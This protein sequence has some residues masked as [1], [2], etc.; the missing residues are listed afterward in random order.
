MSENLLDS[1]TPLA[2]VLAVTVVVCIAKAGTEN[3]FFFRIVSSLR[4]GETGKLHLTLG[5][6]LNSWM[7]DDLSTSS[8]GSALSGENSQDVETEVERYP[9]A[10][11]EIDAPMLLFTSALG[12][13]RLLLWPVVNPDPDGLPSLKFS[14]I[15][16]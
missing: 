2:F 9:L 1:P 15:C 6:G 12:T 5:G 4:F 10:P 16:R 8:V 7:V 13:S 14:R 11:A 3:L